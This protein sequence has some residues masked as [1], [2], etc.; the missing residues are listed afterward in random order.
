M[1]ISGSRPEIDGIIMKKNTQALDY[2]PY[3]YGQKVRPYEIS[4]KLRQGG[5]NKFEYFYS[6]KSF[7][8]DTTVTESETR[9]I[10]V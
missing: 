9:V 3:K 8:K 1:K 4:V 2:M 5:E 6:L 10:E 7:V